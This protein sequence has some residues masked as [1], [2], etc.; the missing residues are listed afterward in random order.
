MRPKPSAAPPVPPPGPSDAVGGS[1]SG[2]RVDASDL[3]DLLAGL[4][5]T[6]LGEALR[7]ARRERDRPPPTGAKYQRAME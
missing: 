2:V 3:D 6:A 7:R 1:P 5:A 4:P